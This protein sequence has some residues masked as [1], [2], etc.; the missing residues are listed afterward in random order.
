M[1]SDPSNAFTGCPLASVIV[2]GRAKNAR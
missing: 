2:A 1:F